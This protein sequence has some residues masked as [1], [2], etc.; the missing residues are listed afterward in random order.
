MA[1]RTWTSHSEFYPVVGKGEIKYA[2]LR[3]PTEL[4]TEQIHDP[5]KLTL[6]RCTL[7]RV[8]SCSRL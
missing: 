2:R 6:L 8:V 3:I 7:P 4:A 5:R 1:G